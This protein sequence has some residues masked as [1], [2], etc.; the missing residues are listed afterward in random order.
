M[1][2]VIVIEKIINEIPTRAIDEFATP[3][4][5]ISILRL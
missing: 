2:G 5:Y 3:R 1:T 4:E